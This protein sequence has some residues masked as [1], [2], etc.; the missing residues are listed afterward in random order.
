MYGEDADFFLRKQ[1]RCY[2]PMIIHEKTIMYFAGASSERQ[3]DKICAVM[4]PK[5]TLLR[6]QWSPRRVWVG[7]VQ[8]WFWGLFRGILAKVH[9][10]VLKRDQLGQLWRELRW[11]LAA[12]SEVQSR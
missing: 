5:S 10:D 8:M 9:P 3:A 11:C 6:C 4:Q 7:M 2:R 12:F 1:A